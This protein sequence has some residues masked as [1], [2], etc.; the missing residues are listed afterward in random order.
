MAT[1]GGFM[2]KVVIVTKSMNLGGSEKALIAM[3]KGIPKHKYR[4]TLLVM[5]IGGAL[6]KE[7]PDWV[8]VKL[9]PGI[10]LNAKNIIVKHL[11]SGKVSQ[12]INSFISLNLMKHSGYYKQYYL[13][14]STLPRIEDEYDLAISYFAPCEYPDWYTAHNIKARKKVVWVHSDVSKF[15]GIYSKYSVKMYSKYDKIFCVSKAAKANFIKIF[16]NLAN[17]VDIFYNIISKHEIVSKAGDAPGFEDDYN[18]LKILTVGRLA[19]EK[20]QDLIPPVLSRLKENGYDLKWYCIGEGPLRKSLMDEIKLYNLA[21]N[22]IL[23]GSKINPYPYFESCDIYVQPSRY[24]A[25]CL[26]VCEAR[27]FNKPI[28]ATNFAG[29][30]EQIINEKTGFIIDFSEEELYLR[31]KELLDN[32]SLRDDFEFN[33]KSNDI[34]TLEELKK[35]DELMV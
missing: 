16:P 4:I 12:S 17:K 19:Q 21:E 9:I 7:I 18:G 20:G 27:C 31:I 8:E 34:N 10:D 32:R 23:L 13:H 6:Y 22:F 5:E 1:K 25:F 24:E 28:V 30:K 14:A 11:K 26:T 35:L 29:I 2:K 33:L 15:E 3:L